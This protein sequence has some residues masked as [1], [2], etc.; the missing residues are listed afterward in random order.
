MVW[1]QWDCKL[2]KG[3][4]PSSRLCRLW[5]WKVKL[6]WAWNQDR[7]AVWDQ[8][9]LSHC[10]HYG[11]V[12][13]WDE[14]RLRWGHNDQSRWD[15]QCSETTLTGESQFHISTTLGIETGSFMTGSKW[16]VHWTIDTWCESSEIAGSPQYLEALLKFGRKNCVE[17]SAL[18]EQLGLN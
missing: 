2:S 15:N 8:A 18:T 10:R 13:V 5:S 9:G 14:A 17:H 6:Q 12:T 11:L 16:V 1:M 7:R 3:L 4:P